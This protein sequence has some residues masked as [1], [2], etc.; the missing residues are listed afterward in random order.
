[1]IVATV[2]STLAMGCGDADLFGPGTGGSNDGTGA[3]DGA[4]GA[5]GTPRFE[6]DCSNGP[7]DAPRPDC[8]PVAL[9]STGDPA[10]DCVNRINQ[11]RWE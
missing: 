8:Q 10:A 5:P 1:M 6:G 7:L 4:A 3:T 11:L 2:V 9:A